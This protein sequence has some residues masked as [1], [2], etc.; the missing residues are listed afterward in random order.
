MDQ[1][2]GDEIVATARLRAALVDHI[3]EAERPPRDLSEAVRLMYED[4]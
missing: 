1:R 2:E 3:E 4:R